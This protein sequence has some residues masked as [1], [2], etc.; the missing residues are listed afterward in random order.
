MKVP[1]ICA[2]LLLSSLVFAGEPPPLPEGGR[3]W[4]DRFAT[5]RVC[6]M[7]HSSSPAALALYDAEARAIGPYDLWQSSMM[8]NSARDP[9][10][11][12]VVSVEMAATPSKAAAI[13]AKCAKC[14]LPL[15]DR[16]TQAIDGPPSGLA[17]I[18]DPGDLGRLARDGASCTLCHRIRPDG[19]G[20]SR[21]FTARFE[22]GETLAAFGPHARPFAMPMRRHSGFT[23]IFGKHILDSGLC[24]TCHTLETN[25][26]AP[27]GKA[28]GGR[29]LEQSPFLEWRA[30]SFAKGS[31][32][33][34][35]ADCHLPTTDE[36]G[37]RIETGIARN[38]GGRDF[39][40][41]RPRSPVGRH[42]LVGGNTL[43][44]ALLRDNAD[45]LSPDAPAEAFDET[46][47]AAR[48]GLR[49]RTAQLEI[50]WAAREGAY[51]RIPVTVTNLTGHKLPTGH[52]MRR[53]WLRFVARDG[54]GRTV[55]AVGRFDERGRIL[56]ADGKP[57]A[58]EIAGG[59]EHT[60]RDV[61]RSPDEVPVWQAVMRD[62]NGRPTRLLMRGA[63]FGRDDRLLPRGFQV[64]TA[65]GRAV[66]PV[67]VAGDENFTGGSDVVTFLVP[68]TGGDGPAAGR[69][70]VVATLVYQTAG[71]RYLAEVLEY[72]T[73]EVRELSGY[74]KSADLR[75]VEI[76]EASA[77]VWSR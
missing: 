18:R 64:D 46:L 53:M 5:S 27:D 57:L 38:P 32:A 52:P 44:P 75:P 8:G 37:R 12:A 33:K 60:H 2:M 59:P 17:L 16:E 61:V 77:T 24:G 15:A 56:G 58:A 19:L 35:C 22:L 4:T 45:R 76:G 42:L 25:A 11:R 50:G 39:P 43:V 67:G 10:W 36:D 66:A 9:L 69:I 70:S 29:L 13:E 54:S 3:V 31:G 40:P 6:A 49:S 30:S 34:S 14:H 41:V 71:A 68:F 7:C 26:L 65:D 51:L 23:P 55:L 1:V 62:S 20:E 28:T 73:P 63:G 74:L 21:T 47:R 72:E 48:E